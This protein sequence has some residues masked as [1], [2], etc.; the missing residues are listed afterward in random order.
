MKQRL[1]DPNYL[2]G[3]EKTNDAG[4]AH[5]I[6]ST[7]LQRDNSRLSLPKIVQTETPNG[8]KKQNETVKSRFGRKRPSLVDDLAK[9]NGDLEFE[10]GGDTG[11][12]D[13]QI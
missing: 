11:S 9:A 12:A 6:K 4:L 7:T 13:H 5:S 1:Y 8:L 2:L 10:N 3:L